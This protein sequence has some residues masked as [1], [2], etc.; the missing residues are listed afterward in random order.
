MKFT[1][2]FSSPLSRAFRTAQAVHNAQSRLHK[3]SGGSLSSGVEIVEVQ[4]LIERDFGFYEGKPFG[5]RSDPKNP[6]A[7]AQ[8]EKSKSEPDVVDMES[9]EAMAAR[10]DRFLESFLLPLFDDDGKNHECVVA[11]VSHGMLLSHFWQRLLQHLPRR[12]LKIAPEI[13][14][15][16]GNV[17][18]EHLGGWSNTGY[19]EISFTNSETPI[20]KDDTEE[21]LSIQQPGSTESDTLP[22]PVPPPLQPEGADVSI[23]PTQKD[24]PA[25]EGKEAP[26]TLTGWSTTILAIDSK[27]HLQGLKRQRGGIG[28]LAH[29]ENQKKLDTFF[30]RPRLT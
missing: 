23:A 16:R 28:S 24:E 7:N 4:E 12:S 3:S 1:H 9:N 19:L 25:P 10:V 5:A 14:A 17:I 11:I 13:T 27:A 20:S 26:R 30:K 21:N 18:L 29:D 6:G 2:I 15:A 22:T 8:N